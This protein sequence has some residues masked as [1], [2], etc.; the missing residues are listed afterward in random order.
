MTRYCSGRFWRPDWH[1]PLRW[2]T[3]L[4]LKYDLNWSD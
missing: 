1:W 4:I 2:L 3:A